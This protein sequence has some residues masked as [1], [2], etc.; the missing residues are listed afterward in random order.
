MLALEVIIVNVFDIE[1]LVGP[2][3]AY[4]RAPLFK[5]SI[6][7]LRSRNILNVHLILALYKTCGSSKGIRLRPRNVI[8]PQS[9]GRRG[10]LLLLV[11]PIWS[12]IIRA[13]L[14]TPVVPSAKR[15]IIPGK[16]HTVLAGEASSFVLRTNIPG[17][18]DMHGLLIH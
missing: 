6:T 13:L 8:C 16:L 5:L 7:W 2:L 15:L 12:L 3:C 4:L 18:S 10:V 1:K 17:L 9:A 14:V 11:C